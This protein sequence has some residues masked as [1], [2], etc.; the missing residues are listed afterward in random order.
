MILLDAPAPLAEGSAGK[1]LMKQK[2]E[3]LASPSAVQAKPNYQQ[4]LLGSI[5]QEPKGGNYDKITYCR[6]LI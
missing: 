3:F 1:L 2:P 6:N 5:E 4:Y